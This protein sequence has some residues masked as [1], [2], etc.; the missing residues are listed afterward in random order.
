MRLLIVLF[1]FMACVENTPFDNVPFDSPVVAPNDNDV[2]VES[3]GM[4]RW[5]NPEYDT[6]LIECA[7]DILGEALGIKMTE[8]LEDQRSFN[9]EI[10]YSATIALFCCP[11]LEVSNTKSYTVSKG[12]TSGTSYPRIE[13]L[14]EFSPKGN[15]FHL[16]NKLPRIPVAYP[17]WV[18]VDNRI[19]GRSWFKYKGGARYWAVLRGHNAYTRASLAAI[20]KANNS[21]M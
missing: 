11:S 3:S 1:L 14:S 12:V 10:P 4:F 7:V 8:H 17:K 6:F 18:R 5:D 15:H 19:A 16:G 21:S 20:K 2:S 9:C 13:K